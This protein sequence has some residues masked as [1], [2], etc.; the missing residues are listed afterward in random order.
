M[1]ELLLLIIDII[2]TAQLVNWVID[3]LMEGFWNWKPGR[4]P[5]LG[6]AYW[7]WHLAE[8][9]TLSIALLMD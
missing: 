6:I 3:V 8:V 5:L 2:E 7:I 4:G 9:Y 1:E